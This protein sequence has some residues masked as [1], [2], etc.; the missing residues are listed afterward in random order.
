MLYTG[1]GGLQRAPPT[2]FHLLSQ[3]PVP[4][5]LLGTPELP[6][7]ATVQQ[8]DKNQAI[9]RSQP[10]AARGHT[11]LPALSQNPR[12]LPNSLH[13]TPTQNLL[14]LQHVTRHREAT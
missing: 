12:L 7:E 6:G 9:Q 13:L 2:L 4:G 8:D 3:L 10:E 14:Q 5:F 1:G 11:V